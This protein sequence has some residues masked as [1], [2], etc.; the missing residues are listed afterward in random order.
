MYNWEGNVPGA[1]IGVAVEK[2]QRIV[3]TKIYSV[4]V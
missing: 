4:C 2:E 3:M 1:G